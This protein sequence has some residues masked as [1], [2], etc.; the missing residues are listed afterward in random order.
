MLLEKIQMWEAF[1]VKDLKDCLLLLKAH[2]VSQKPEKESVDASYIAKL[3]AQDGGFW[4]AATTNLKRIKAFLEKMD[5]LALQANM[6]P[7][8]VSLQNR[9]E[10]AQKVDKILEAIDMKPK[11]FSWKMRA[12][13]G[14]KKKW[15]NPVERPETVGGFGIWETLLKEKG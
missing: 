14:T 6:D 13:I 3:L 15:Y 9:E 2:G 1:S 7:K 12:K 11:P 4:Y 5:E 8:Q 10:I